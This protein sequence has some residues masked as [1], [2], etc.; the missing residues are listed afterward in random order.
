MEENA[1]VEVEQTADVQQEQ[2][3]EEKTFTQDELNSI[4]AKEK[5]K[6]QKKVDEEKEEE[7]KKAKMNAEEKAKFELEKSQNALKER[8]NALI[9]RELTATAKDIL[10]TKGLPSNLHELLV[11][12]SE[13]TVNS[14]IEKLEKVINDTVE[15]LVTEKL[16]GTV[17][18]VGTQQSNTTPKWEK[19]FLR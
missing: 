4:L 10:A 16:K 2:K 11:Y 18:K 5:S 17:P 13:E 9:K 3:Q 1:N 8:E 19:D 6:W 14:S 15:K 7:R 12:E